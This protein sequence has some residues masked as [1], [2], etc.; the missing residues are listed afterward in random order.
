MT[1]TQKRVVFLF[2][3]FRVDDCWV[4]ILLLSLHQSHF[5]QVKNSPKNSEHMFVLFLG[6]AEEGHQCFGEVLEGGLTSRVH[7]EDWGLVEVSLKE[8]MS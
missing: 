5:A 7:S 1:H 3:T 6:D 2:L 8:V 4:A